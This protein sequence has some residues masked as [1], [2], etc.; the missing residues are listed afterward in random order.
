MDF[1]EGYFLQAYE[2]VY[3]IA[4]PD[5]RLADKANALGDVWLIPQEPA[6]PHPA[7][8]PV[9]LAQRCINSTTGKIV[10]DPFIGSGTNAIAAEAARRD[11]IGMDISQDYCKLARE[12][13]MAL[14][15][16]MQ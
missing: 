12:R 1:D 15:R 16:L 7:P 6:N 11:W 8:F 4:K 14:R 3:L 10:L 5:F 13:I 2:V 9:E